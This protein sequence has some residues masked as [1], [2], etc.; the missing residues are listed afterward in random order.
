MSCSKHCHFKLPDS[1][2]TDLGRSESISCMVLSRGE[3]G[4]S[5]SGR[6]VYTVEGVILSGPV[7]TPPMTGLCV[8]PVVLL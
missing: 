5:I 6:L 1:I 3:L 7:A 4:D 8:L 2:I